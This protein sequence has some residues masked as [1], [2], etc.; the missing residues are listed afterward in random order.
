MSKFSQGN[1]SAVLSNMQSQ[2]SQRSSIFGRISHS[3]HTSQQL[4]QQNPTMNL[5]D[6]LFSEKVDI[7]GKIYPENRNGV[8]QAILKIILK[9][10]MEIVRL[11]TFHRN[12]FQQIQVDVEFI[13]LNFWRFVSNEKQVNGF[14]DEIIQS[15]M[16]RSKDPVLM[17]FSVI[18]K[19]LSNV[20]NT[21]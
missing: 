4:Q 19:I 8:L 7:Y 9:T 6:S 2:F 17:E 16:G 1:Q 5:I 20:S 11:R 13:R 3:G 12:G 18:E 21:E 14:L 15:T 10:F